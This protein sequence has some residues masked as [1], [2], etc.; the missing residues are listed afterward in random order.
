[1][2]SLRRWLFRSMGRRAPTATDSDM[3]PALGISLN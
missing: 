3:T 1:M 2:L